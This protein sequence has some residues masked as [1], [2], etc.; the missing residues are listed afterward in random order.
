M[1]EC[2]VGHIVLGCL[3]EGLGVLVLLLVVA[4]AGQPRTRTLRAWSS[5][6]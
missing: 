1:I 2:L 4:T 6:A 5:R 3:S